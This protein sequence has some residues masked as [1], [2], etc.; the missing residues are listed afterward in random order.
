[1]V[2][3]IILAGA[4][5]NLGGRIAL[6][7]SKRGANVDVLLRSETSD[8]KKQKSLV[9][10]GLTV[11]TVDMSNVS[12][13]TRVCEGA[14]CVVSAL[15]GLRNVVV[16]TQTVL[17]EAALAAGV[18]RFIPSDFS[19]DF[20][21]LTPGGNR[22]YDL[23]REFQQRLD[24]AAIKPTSIFNGVFAEVLTQKVPY[25]DLEKKRI[26]YWEDPDWR[27]DFSTMDDTAAYTSAAALDPA[28]PRAL[29]IASFGVTPRELA[30]FTDEVLKTPFELVRLGSLEELN[31]RN[32]SERA[33]DPE[34]EN[35]L[36]PPWQQSQYED[37]MFSVHHDSLDNGRY[38][39]VKWTSLTDFFAQHP[40]A[41]AA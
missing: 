16:D 12:E 32:K 21:L 15:Q 5:G 34:G 18:A 24:A 25:L 41:S 19:T 14:D 17:L 31:L 3:K 20:R 37:S 27:L 11:R 2:N 23:R 30:K 1:M 8:D 9:D 28:T 40:E 29:E 39:D 7:L 26:G 36:Y 22:N 33:A 38:P 35:E 6:A 13:L 4:T 10:L